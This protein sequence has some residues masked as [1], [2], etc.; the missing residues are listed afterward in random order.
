VNIDFPVTVQGSFGRS[1][2]TDR[3]RGGAPLRVRT[4]NGGVRITRK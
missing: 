1:F 4:S 2:S 3:G